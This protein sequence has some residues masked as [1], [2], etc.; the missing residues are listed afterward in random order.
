MHKEKSIQQYYN[1]LAPEYDS[2]RFA[3]SY[4]KYLHVQETQIMGEWLRGI[5]QKEIL[6]MG[7]G[8]GRF[9]NYAHYGVDISEGMLTE[10][11]AK[12]PNKELQIASI[13]NTP[14]Q[15]NTF[16]AIFSLHV[17]FHLEEEIIQQTIQEAHRILKP[18]GILIFDFP[19]KT[20]REMI[21]YQKEGW[22]GNTALSLE[23]VQQYVGGKFILEKYQGVMLFPVH[24][25]PKFFRS[26]F[27]L[28]DTLLSQSFLK[29][30][31]SYNF[32]FLHRK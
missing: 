10:A 16:Q 21:N 30:W 9:L 7:C 12:F 19:S 18:N 14:F 27:R 25:I 24:R 26:S 32:V 4:G 23:E 13:T 15:D 22:H 5:S 28:V 1:D 29:K 17:F 11:K 2:D 20:R 3:N 31:A 8:T 6:D